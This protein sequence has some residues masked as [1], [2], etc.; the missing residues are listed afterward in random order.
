[1]PKLDLTLVIKVRAA[2]P[3]RCSNP[4]HSAFLAP[5]SLSKDKK[6]IGWYCLAS[7]EVILSAR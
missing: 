4:G 3:D 1:M 6:V 5:S 7:L 2:H